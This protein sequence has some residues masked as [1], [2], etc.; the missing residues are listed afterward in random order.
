MEE[1][2]LDFKAVLPLPEACRC[3]IRTTHVKHLNND[4]VRPAIGG[5][6]EYWIWRAKDQKNAKWKAN[7]ASYS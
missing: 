6:N 1:A 7:I 3:Y 4:S 2:F 5:M